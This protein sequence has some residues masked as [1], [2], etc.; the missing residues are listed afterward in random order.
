M[1]KK[2]ALDTLLDLLKIS[3]NAP[4]SAISD[5]ILNVNKYRTAQKRAKDIS[6]G[7]IG[8]KAP[9]S[10]EVMSDNVDAKDLGEYLQQPDIKMKPSDYFPESKEFHAPVS[11]PSRNVSTRPDMNVIPKQEAGDITK[12]VSKPEVVSELP[13]TIKKPSLEDVIETS[14]K[15][16]NPGMSLLTKLGIGAGIGGGIYGLSQLGDDNSGNIQRMSVQPSQSNPESIKQTNPDTKIKSVQGQSNIEKVQANPVRQ[17][18][19]PSDLDKQQSYHQ[20]QL[21][22]LQ[23]LKQA[24]QQASDLGVAGAIIKAGQAMNEA[25]TGVKGPDFAGDLQQHG[26]R[27]ISN[28]D[29]QRK[30]E[31][32]NR[33]LNTQRDLNNPNSPLASQLRMKL[34]K[35]GVN[36][37]EGMSVNQIQKATGL[38]LNTLL[39]YEQNEAARRESAASRKEIANILA[40]EKAE[41]KQDKENQRELE[42]LDKR[43]LI[44]EE[45]EGF[46]RNIKSNIDRVN[47]LI[48]K[49]GTVEATGPESE[50]LQGILNEIATD[51]AKLQDPKSIARPSE[52]HLVRQSLV[53]ESTTGRMFMR[54]STAKQILNTFKDRVDERANTAYKVRGVDLEP[55]KPKSKTVIQNGHTY[56]L[57]ESTGEYE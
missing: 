14:A 39:G 15:E 10:K 42:R 55:S 26:Q 57:N 54:D 12:Y 11:S 34:S 7:N 48:D 41:A 45:V 30:M 53:P 33:E 22:Y 9:Y 5:D 35:F 8:K 47:Q 43:K 44:T 50:Q 20:E 4:T 18:S 24:Q 37:P 2:Q 56:T 3:D 6:K 32:A 17:E 1:S 31:E 23:A 40:K 36:V 28:I 49:V 52:V 25:V 16:A 29:D 38:N 46:R 13:A 51:M 21:D 27:L 19:I